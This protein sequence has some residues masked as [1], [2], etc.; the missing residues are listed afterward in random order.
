MGT[1][2]TTLSAALLG[3][4]LACIASAVAAPKASP[5]PSPSPVVRR[6]A[7]P[8]IYHTVVHPVCSALSAKIRPA[9]G[10]L[11]ENDQLIGKSPAMFKEYGMAQ[12]NQSDAQK[13]LT[14][15]HMEN[16]VTPLANNVLA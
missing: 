3:A 9:I 16:L 7:P 1:M 15:L 10:M 12:F 13:N 2:R 14:I 11:L 5:R 6:T 4:F 8:E